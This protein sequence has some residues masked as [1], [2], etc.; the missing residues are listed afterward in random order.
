MGRGSLLTI[1]LAIQVQCFWARLQERGG[2]GSLCHVLVFLLI[3]SGFHTTYFDHIL[4]PPSAP[5]L[6]SF[7][8]F[9]DRKW[10]QEVD[11]AEKRRKRK[12]TQL[13][14]RGR[15]LQESKTLAV[16]FHDSILSQQELHRTT[17]HPSPTPATPPRTRLLRWPL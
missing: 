8:R 17:N 3:L 10:R 15:K 11:G 16:P 1:S 4:S 12:G 5:S 9:L 14:R 2:D 13:C 6:I 7:I